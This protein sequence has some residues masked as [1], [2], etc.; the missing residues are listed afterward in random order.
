MTKKIELQTPNGRGILGSKGEPSFF[1]SD[2]GFVMMRIW[3]ETHDTC[4][5]I[6]VSELKE[7][8]P[9]GYT[10]IEKENI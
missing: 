1:V 8:L 9:S 4:R 7:L 6:K 3:D 2:L 5:N 10:I